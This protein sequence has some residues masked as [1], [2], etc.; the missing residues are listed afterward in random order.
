MDTDNRRP[1]G[2]L[3]PLRAL[4]DGLLA[5]VQGRMELFSLELREEKFRLIRT[6]VWV[7]AAVFLGMLAII[8]AS[9]TVVYLFWDSARLAVLGGL[10]VFHTAA[11]AAVLLALRRF[12]ARQPKPFAATLQEFAKDRACIHKQN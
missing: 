9:L 12:L 11:L 8:F 10:A 5:A 4:G 7:T 6:V 3:G 1:S 2:L